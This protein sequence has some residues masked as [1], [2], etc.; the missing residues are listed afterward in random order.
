M[1]FVGKVSIVTF[2][3]CAG[4]TAVTFSSDTIISMFVD[5]KATGAASV[6]TTIN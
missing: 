2:L 3:T 6:C 4:G 5:G 1:A